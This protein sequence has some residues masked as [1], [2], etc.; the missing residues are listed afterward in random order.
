MK[1]KNPDLK[2]LSELMKNS[3]ISD[4]TLAKKIGISQPTVTRR[5][6]KLE[7]EGFVKEYTLVPN[8]SKIGYHIMA[9]TLFKYGTDVDEAVMDAAR[10]KAKHV[11]KD[12]PW[13]M[14]MAERGI[15]IDYDGVTISYHRTY[16]DFAT[17]RDRVRHLLP[18]KAYRVD[19]FLVNLDDTVHYRPL[20]FSTLATH[21]LEP[22]AE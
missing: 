18:T 11:I 19:S 22:P 21:L 10:E 2:I 13:E 14:V 12:S 4:R 8:F 5:R 6:A 9:I 20:T 15:G 16:G 7:A 3:K 1:T 17:F